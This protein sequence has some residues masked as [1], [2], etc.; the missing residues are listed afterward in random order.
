MTTK[1]FVEKGRVKLVGDPRGLTIKTTLRTDYWIWCQDNSIKTEYQGT[2]SGWD[3]WYIKN[4]KD[5][6]LAVLKWS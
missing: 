6:M 1:V 4:K 2:L 3:L 5:R